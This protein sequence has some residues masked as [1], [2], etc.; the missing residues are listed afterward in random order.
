MTNMG[1]P[2]SRRRQ[3][4][5]RRRGLGSVVLL[6]TASL[7][8]SL[9][10]AAQAPPTSAARPPAA[11]PGGDFI[12]GNYWALV[13]GINEYPNL[14]AE[15]QLKAARPGAEA[16][17]RLLRQYG[18]ERDR[19]TQ[20]YDE[21]AT[22]DGILNPLRSL[23]ARKEVTP[24]DSVLIYFAGHCAVDPK[25]KTAAW[26][27]SAADERDPFSF[28]SMD[29]LLTVVK[30][31]EARHVFLIMD[32]CVGD[33]LVGA[34]KISGNPSVRE[35]YQKKSRWVLASG[36]PAPMPEIGGAQPGPSL[37]TRALIDSL[38]ENRLAYLTPL[39]LGEEM[40][41]R[42]PS[43]AIRILKNG[44]MAKVPGMIDAGDDNGQF[45]FRLDGASPPTAEI[46]V[47]S[48]EE[49][50]V[51]RMRWEIAQVQQ[52]PLRQPLKDQAVASLQRQMDDIRKKIEDE[53]RAAQQDFAAIL[54]AAAKA[55]AEKERGVVE[56]ARP[57]D[58]GPM[59][60]IPAGEF[61]MG[62]TPRDGQI[63]EQP[64]K[65]IFLDAFY[66]DKHET[67]V[68]RYARYL[69]ASRSTKPPR[70]WD[71]VNATSDQDKDLPVVG[72]DWDEANNYCKWAGKRL[73]SEAEWEKAAR[74]TDGRRHPWGNEGNPQQFANLGIGGTFGYSKS[75][76]KVGSFETG[77]SPYDVYD[78]IGNVWEWTADWY[79]RAY[80]KAMPDKNPKGPEKGTERVVR[81]GSWERVPLVSRVAARH[82]VR[83]STQ[84]EY[85]GFRCAKDAP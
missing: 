10:A 43:D 29:E 38:S 55:Q 68:G 8:L 9:P 82:R 61:T 24:D 83:P 35:V 69:S 47:P 45:V 48:P 26:L 84:A 51:S 40:V 71:Q 59:V 14:P 36:A 52:M 56:S 50:P 63:D 28:I 81:G 78:M 41:K 66:I 34:S 44:P 39:H 18:V 5:F 15:K 53:R 64:Q 60:Q 11:A 42:L 37:F 80:Y 70:L 75:L 62:S 2:G 1:M 58:I 20:L 30:N 65:R 67:T 25:S 19:L 33:V 16:L 21:N 76:K 46:R 27:P 57:E 77:K 31:L 74:G 13:V 72:V 85:L 49:P 22:K 4:V 73:P 17:A 12:Q 54:A 23:S 32:S 6:L 7:L 79:D 3:K